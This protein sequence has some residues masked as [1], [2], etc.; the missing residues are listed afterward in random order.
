MPAVCPANEQSYY[1]PVLLHGGE[2]HNGKRAGKELCRED[3]VAGTVSRELCRLCRQNCREKY[4]PRAVSQESPEICV[5]RLVSRGLCRES[6]LAR[7][8]T[9]ELCRENFVARAV[10]RGM[11]CGRW[12]ESRK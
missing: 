3:F 12:N 4:V 10:S 11:S 2:R 9:R 7:T 5:A 1:E 6:C 8:V